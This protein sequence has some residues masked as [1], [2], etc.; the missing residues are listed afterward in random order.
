MK[1]IYLDN[2]ATTKPSVEVIESIMPYLSYKWYNPSSLYSP[3]AKI[4][5]KIEESREIIAEFIGANKGEVYFT[6]GG[7]EGNSWVIQGFVNECFVSGKQPIIITSTIEHKSILNCVN[8]LNADVYF[9]KVDNRGFVTWDNL[10]NTLMK[11]LKYQKD[12][13]IEDYGILVSIQLAN[14]EIGTVQNAKMISSIV[15]E[16]GGVLHMDSVQAFGHIPINVKE[17]GID[18][19]TASGHKVNAL[20]GSGFMYKNDSVKIKPLIYGTQENSMRG[21]TENVIGI[22]S[23]G[24]A[25]KHIDFGENFEAIEELIDKRFYFINL[26][27][28]K[29]GCELNGCDG[30]RLPNNINVTFP[31]NITGESLLYTLEMSDIFVSTGSACNSKFIKPSYVLKAIGLSDEEAMRTIRITLPNDITYE[32]IDKVISEIEKSLKLI[33]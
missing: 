23:L 11:A 33:E 20:K 1:E 13:Y 28:S 14:N 6:S 30:Y 29:F 9:V 7:S 32:Q 31:Q 2:A 5:E 4:K 10:E 26:L 16:Y 12:N 15:H 17:L 24:E 18:I 3:S 19:L 8:N 25:V 27:E 21:G 22:I